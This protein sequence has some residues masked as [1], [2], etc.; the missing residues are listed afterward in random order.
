MECPR[1][2]KHSL[3]PLACGLH[4]YFHC[5]PFRRYLVGRPTLIKGAQ[6]SKAVQLFCA[7]PVAIDFLI[8]FVTTLLKENTSKAG[9]IRNHS[10]PT[11]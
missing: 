7:I 8:V 5:G 6:W 4:L 1:V 3:K 2:H 9:N 11:T 10:F